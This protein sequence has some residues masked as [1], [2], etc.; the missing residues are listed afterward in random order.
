MQCLF[1]L[2]YA[3]QEAVGDVLEEPAVK[4]DDDDDVPIM[5]RDDDIFSTDW[6][7]AAEKGFQE[8]VEGTD[9]QQPTGT[10]RTCNIKKHRP[11]ESRTFPDGERVDSTPG[12]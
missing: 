11:A 6:Q 8:T 5:E 4:V 1:S 10:V 12:V 9:I 3:V 7:T 2:A